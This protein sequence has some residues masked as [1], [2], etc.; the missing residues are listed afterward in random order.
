MTPEPD[1][2]PPGIL[3]PSGK[4]VQTAKDASCPRCG[5]PPEK[6]GPSGGFGIRRPLCYGCGYRWEDEVWHD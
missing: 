5:A 2:T 1:P 3:D 4:P 6:R